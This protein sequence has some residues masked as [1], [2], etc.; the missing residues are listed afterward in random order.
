MRH[1]TSGKKGERGPP[2]VGFNLDSNGNFDIENKKMT[3]LK[4]GENNQDCVN[5]SQLDSKHYREI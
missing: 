3:N 2:G 5:K 1:F 4:N